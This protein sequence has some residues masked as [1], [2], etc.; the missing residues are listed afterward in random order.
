MSTIIR[1]D[2]VIL[3][4][5]FG[6]LKMIGQTFEVANI[7][8]KAVV[9]RDERTKVAVAAVDIEE[10]DIYFKKVIDGWSDWTVLVAQ[11]G[12]TMGWYRTNGKKVQVKTNNGERAEATCNKTDEFNLYIGVNMAFNRCHKKF[13]MDM[14][15]RLESELLSVE[16]DIKIVNEQIENLAKIA[17]P[18]VSK[19]TEVK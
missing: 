6:K 1:N 14:K 7:T 4:K 10:F 15:S 5:E 13:L 17:K 12:V 3:V 9:I 19:N 18:I 2:K 11:N 16:N 8:D